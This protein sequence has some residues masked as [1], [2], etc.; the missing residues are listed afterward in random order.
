MQ[1]LL[2]IGVV[3]SFLLA[4]VG[5][6]D[7]TTRETVEER[8]IQFGQPVLA[9]ISEQTQPEAMA[10]YD[11]AKRFVSDDRVDTSLFDLMNPGISHWCPPQPVYHDW[12]VHFPGKKS[13]V[14]ADSVLSI[15]VLNDG[16]CWIHR[17]G[18]AV[19]SAEETPQ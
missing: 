14:E 16:E 19:E 18:N 2:R 11:H 17:P 9:G 8:V 6:N 1:C 10:A 3:S 4:A 12:L 15:A 5:C 7:E 13:G